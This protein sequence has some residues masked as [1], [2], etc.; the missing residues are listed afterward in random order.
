VKLK[1]GFLLRKV[2]S[3][4][5]LV[6]MSNTGFNGLVKMNDT[7]AFI[8]GLLANE[9]NEKELIDAVGRKYQVDL[10]IAKDDVKEVISTLS[11]IQAL[12]E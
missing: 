3:E 5:L 6:G 12:T 10:N 4:N 8:V 1:E 2:G 7:A 9:M 11:S